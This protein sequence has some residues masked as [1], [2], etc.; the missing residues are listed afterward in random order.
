M[1]KKKMP[2]KKESDGRLLFVL[3]GAVIL[4]AVFIA[5]IILTSQDD[6]EPA[7]TTDAI[8][9]GA[10][11]NLN[12]SQSSLDIPSAQGARLAAREIN[13]HGGVNGRPVSLILYDGRS[14]TT[15]ITAAANRLVTEDR[16][17]VL[18]GMS[19]SD[20]VLPA[21]QVAAKSGVVFVTSGATSPLLPAQ[22]PGYLYLSCFGDNT[23]AAVAAEFALSDLNAT[24]AIVITDRSMEYTRLLSQYFTERFTNGGGTI[25]GTVQYDGGSGNNS[26]AHITS[27]VEN[28]HPDIVFV[29]CGPADCGAVIRAVR[30]AGITAP[31]IGGD[32]FDSPQLSDSVGPD[33]D[34]IYYTT[35]ADISTSSSDRNVSAF[36]KRYYLEYGEE[37]NAFAALGYDAVNIVAQAMTASGDLREGLAAIQGY[38]G[39]TGTISYRNL[40]QMPEKSVTIMEIKNGMVVAIGE[41]MPRVIP[42]P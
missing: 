11:Y 8:R 36:I 25:T 17:Q 24:R 9:I 34:R 2:Q 5:A 38:D 30:E 1:K 4:A 21:A 28:A 15:E 13:E 27:G 7:N 12:G 41:R 26:S 6:S 18:L 20:M 14:N 16:V 37:P 40:S 23:Q 42:A 39:L 33:A 3:A 10:I 32:S 19:D 22:V 29:A 31:I 35:H